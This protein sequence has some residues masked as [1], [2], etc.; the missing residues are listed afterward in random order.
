MELL[1]E[2]EKTNG[3]FAHMAKVSQGLRD[4]M[5]QTKNWE[6]LNAVQRE[7]LQMIAHKIARILAGDPALQNHWNDIAG[8]ATLVSQRLPPMKPNE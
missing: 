5:M 6:S 3:D 2:R 7:S 4:S 1:K 8:Y